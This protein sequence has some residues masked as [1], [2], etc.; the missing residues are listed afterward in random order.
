[1]HI[2]KNTV[3]KELRSINLEDKTLQVLNYQPRWTI[4]QLSSHQNRNCCNK[5]TIVP[6][7]VTETGFTTDIPGTN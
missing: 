5:T 4:Y 1:M 3:K 6:S 7:Y 2:Q